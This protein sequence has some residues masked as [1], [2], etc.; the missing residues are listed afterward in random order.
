MWP[1]APSPLVLAISCLVPH[2]LGGALYAISVA[3]S[4]PGCEPDYDDVPTTRLAQPLPAGIN[5]FD[6]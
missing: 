6:I 2:C 3:P 1:P 5:S 4:P